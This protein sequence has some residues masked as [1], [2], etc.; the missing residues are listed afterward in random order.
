MAKLNKLVLLFLI[1]F[2]FAALPLAFAQGSKKSSINYESAQCK[3]FLAEITEKLNNNW[4]SP[5]GNNKVT[6]TCT[7]ESDGSAV[8]VETTSNPSSGEAENIANSAYIKAQPFGA[9][10]VSAGEKARLKVE[11][12]S[13]VDPHGESSRNIYASLG[14]V[15]SK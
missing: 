7:L 15:P 10:P 5:D 6:I 4:F 12:V 11:F 3:A 9:L 1:L 2:V 14:P 13:N 8:D